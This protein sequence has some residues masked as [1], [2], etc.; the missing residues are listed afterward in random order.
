MKG[1]T[2]GSSGVPYLASA[3]KLRFFPEL[4]SLRTTL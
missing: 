2:G 3:L 1:G 4:Y